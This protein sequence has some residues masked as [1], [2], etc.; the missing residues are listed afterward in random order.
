MTYMEQGAEFT[1]EYGDYF[2]K[3]RNLYPQFSERLARVEQTE[4]V[5]ANSSPKTQGNEAS[6]M[7]ETFADLKQALEGCGCL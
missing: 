5:K 3:R 7:N 6:Y 4:T 1:S 2:A